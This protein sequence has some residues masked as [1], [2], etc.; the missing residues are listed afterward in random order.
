VP[1]LKSTVPDLGVKVPDPKL[2][3]PDLRSGGIR[4]NLTPDL[5]YRIVSY[6]RDVLTLSVTFITSLPEECEIF[7]AIV[8]SVCLSARK[9]QKAPLVQ[10][11]RNIQYLLPVAVHCFVLHTQRCNT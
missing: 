9:S 7:Y 1:D 3:V 10:T 2:D 6:P 4:L 11:S 5:P 8:V